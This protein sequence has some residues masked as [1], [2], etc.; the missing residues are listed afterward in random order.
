MLD[1]LV[2]CEGQTEREF[3]NSLLSP[4]LAQRGIEL[5][6]TLRGKPQQKRG[7]ICQWHVYQRELLRLAKE[8]TNRHVAVLVDY[9]KMDDTWPGR[10]EAS[11]K[12]PDE[13]GLFVEVALRKAM[14]SQLGLRFHPCVALHEFESLMFVSPDITANTLASAGSYCNSG[15]L[16]QKLAGIVE[17]FHGLVEMINDSEET[18]PSKRLQ[19]LV[20][21][22]DKVAY[23]TLVAKAVGIDVLRRGCPWLN[24]WL[25][26]LEQGND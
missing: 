14:D 2:L 5:R 19:Q 12:K 20:P 17:T 11:A 23:G 15:I 1:V 26:V 21:Y 25:D 4:Y 16:A 13:R 24:R 7:G 22:Y 9:Y 10:Q 18:A 3:C 8:R 6:A